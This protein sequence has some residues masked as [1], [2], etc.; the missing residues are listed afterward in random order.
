M[1]PGALS[2][3]V[4]TRL[5]RLRKERGLS[6]A[7]LADP[8]L[9][10]SYLSLIESGAR[11]PSGKVLQ[12]LA[13]RLG[14]E[15]EEL[16][17][18]R[19][20][21]D[22]M[23]LDLQLQE[24]RDHLRLGRLE[25]AAELAQQVA[26]RAAAFESVRIEAKSYE[27]LGTVEERRARIE[28]A[29]NLYAR[30]EG[31]WEPEPPHLAFETMAGLARC[32][33]ALGDPRLAVHLLETYLLRLDR[34]GVP[35]PIA[36]MRAHSTLVICYSALGLPD[37]AA[38]AADRAEALSPRV[39][40]SEQLACMRMNV[41]R[42]L[43]ERGHMDDALDAIRSAE[44]AFLTL[45]WQ[46][47]AAAAKLNRSIV[48]IDKGDLDHARMNLT[49]ALTTY[50][51]ANQPLHTARVLNELGRLERMAGKPD[52]AVGLL[53]EAQELLGSGDFA[54]RAL[55]LR[56]LGLCLQEKTPHE[57]KGHL[58]RAIDLYLLAGASKEVATT[59]KFLGDAHRKDGEVGDSADAY[60]AGIEAL[61]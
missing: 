4:G 38:A 59:Y 15:A 39:L 47:D 61:E 55:N 21:K 31:L 24:A 25:A 53:E 36:T 22:E 50:R 29:L 49:E 20:R 14:V 23:G 37:K 5:K 26:E 34:E 18:G 27:V 51:E 44:Q 2:S 7:E 3:E 52:V 11:R 16:V 48:Q 12:H 13:A 57:A 30:A 43:Y 28:S 58:R 1:S 45:G 17:T 54:E 10:P 32:Q 42:S 60:R 56:E 46:V 33:L 8:V 6:Q 9:S 19:S 40:D 41:A 35:D